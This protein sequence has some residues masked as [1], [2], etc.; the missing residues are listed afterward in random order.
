MHRA[1]AIGGR[2][3]SV[4][5]RGCRL[6]RSQGTT[7]TPALVKLNSVKRNCVLLI[8]IYWRRRRAVN[9]SVKNALR[10]IATKTGIVEAGNARDRRRETASLTGQHIASALR[11]RGAAIRD[12]DNS[13][14]TDI[15]PTTT[16]STSARIKRPGYRPSLYD[17]QQPDGTAISLAGAAASSIKTPVRAGACDQGFQVAAAR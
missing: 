1:R 2:T 10:R 16:I 9:P 15:E 5:Q 14:L 12:N 3:R 7:V 11:T 17:R 8:G 13:P 4:R 6:Y